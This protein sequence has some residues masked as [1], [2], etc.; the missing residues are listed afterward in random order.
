L[1]FLRKLPQIYE[2]ELKD[3][4]TKL[5]DTL[6]QLEKHPYEKRPFVYLDI[7]SWLE[8]K[9][10]GRTVQEVIRNKFLRKNNF[11]P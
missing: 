6:L 7:I 11:R 10:E 8:S 2:Y 9:I 5:R 1:K 4:F 3:E